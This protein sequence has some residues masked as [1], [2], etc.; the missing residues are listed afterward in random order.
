[1]RIRG[2]EDMMKRGYEDTR[3][4]VQLNLSP[5]ATEAGHCLTSQ[6]AHL[7]C[8]EMGGLVQPYIFSLHFQ[9]F[10]ASE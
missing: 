6:V 5:S 10:D 2:Y 4:M 3:Y 1:M 9:F 7:V 8:L